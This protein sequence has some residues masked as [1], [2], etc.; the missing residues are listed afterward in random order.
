MTRAAV[1]GV[2]VLELMEVAP[3][4]RRAVVIGPPNPNHAQ[5]RGAGSGPVFD[6]PRLPA[7]GAGAA[8]ALG[9]QR[10]P[11]EL[12]LHHLRPAPPSVA[13][14]EHTPPAKPAVS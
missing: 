6:Q 4:T 1:Y 13:P 12:T 9:A 3:V 8:R 7:A 11:P 2:H 14:P 5:R 10:R